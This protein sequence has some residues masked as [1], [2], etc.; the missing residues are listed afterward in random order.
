MTLTN[1]KSKGK[2]SIFSTPISD[3]PSASDCSPFCASPSAL[4][5][6][7]CLHSNFGASGDPSPS[8]ASTDQFTENS[9]QTGIPR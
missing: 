4:G 1:F 2:F 8:G 3:K 6:L 5:K 9:G 7:V